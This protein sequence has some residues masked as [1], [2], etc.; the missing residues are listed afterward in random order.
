MLYFLISNEHLWHSKLL[1]IT[2]LFLFVVA[3]LK[4]ARTIPLVL[5]GVV[6][7]LHHARAYFDAPH[8]LYAIFNTYFMSYKLKLHAQW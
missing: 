8:I 5:T 1:C 6:L 7:P 4:G 3:V 2:F